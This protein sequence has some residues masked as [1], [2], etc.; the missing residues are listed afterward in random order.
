MEYNQLVGLRNLPNKMKEMNEVKAYFADLTDLS[1]QPIDAHVTTLEAGATLL[2]A[3]RTR[4]A[5]HEMVLR[6]RVKNGANYERRFIGFGRDADD[7]IRAVKAGEL[8]Q[9]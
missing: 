1:I 4:Y 6:A 7:F 5:D 9:A 2:D 3:L 8:H